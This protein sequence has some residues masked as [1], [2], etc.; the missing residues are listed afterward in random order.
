MALYF[1]DIQSGR[2]FFADEEGL[3]LPNQKAA[4]IEAMQTLI[5][6]AKDSVFGSERPDMAVEVRSTIDRLFCVSLV[7]RNTGTMH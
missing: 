6:M 4:E 5:G 7:Y 2:D 3:D 1:F